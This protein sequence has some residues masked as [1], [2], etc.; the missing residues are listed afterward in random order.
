MIPGID[1]GNSRFKYAVGDEAG[2]PKIITNLYGESFTPSAVYFAQDGSIVIGTEALNAGFIEPSRLVVN[3]KRDM[4]TDKP[5]Y[6]ADDGIVYKARDILAILLKD[7]KDN[8][9]AKTGQVI[10]EAVITVP[11]NYND[12]QKQHTIDAAASVGMKAILLPHEPTAAALGNQ[13]YKHKGSTA[14]VFDLGGGTFDVSIVSCKGN[15]MD[16]IATGGEQHL[17]GRDFNDRISE[18]L[19]EEFET[20]NGFRPSPEEHPVFYQE[21]MQRIEQLKISLSVQ[22]QSQVVLFCEGKQLQM[23]I[24]RQQFNQWV[25]DLAE[26]TMEKTEQT[27]KEAN[28]DFTDIDEVYAVGGGSMMPIV[29]EMLEELTGKKVS[30]RC[31]PHCAA[32][33]GAVLAGRIECERQGKTYTCGDVALPGPGLIVH[34][35]LSHTIG[36]MA[37][38]QDDREVCSQ[39]LAKDTPIPSIQT[40][41]FKLSQPNQTAVTIQILEGEDGQGSKDCLVLGHFDLNDLPPR[42]DLIGRVEVTFSLDENGL[43]SAKARDSVSG[44]EEQMQI[45]YDTKNKQADAA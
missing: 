21:M 24:T 14:V 2:N 4:G 20:K 44:K 29:T 7:A 17:G 25:L 41:L 36:V 35:I 42:P 37:L 39:I 28:L 1:A 10:N 12:I 5:L 27:V 45:D 43:L 34:E 9:E 8:I 33:L 22:S 16:I 18:K 40:K 3:W 6:T 15:T 11:A 31:Q 13:L 26:K 19:L 38:D 32:A 30:R 23:T